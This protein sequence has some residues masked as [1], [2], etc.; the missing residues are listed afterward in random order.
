VTQFE[1]QGDPAKGRLFVDPSAPLN[2][3]VDVSSIALGVVLE[4]HGDIIEDDAWLRPK[5]D[6]SHIKQAEL[7]AAI[8]GINRARLWGHHK[9]TLITDSVTVHSWL[10]AVIH[11]TRNVKTRALIR[12][13]LSWSPDSSKTRYGAGNYR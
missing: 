11:R 3:W 12:R 5:N 7:D 9:F 4:V 6:S 2:I 10:H 13:S 1:T 8:Y